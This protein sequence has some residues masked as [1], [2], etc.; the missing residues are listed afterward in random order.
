MTILPPMP[1]ADGLHPILVHFPIALLLTAPVFI[2]LAAAWHARRREML[3]SALVLVALGTLGAVAA[4]WSGE[5]GEHA[6][7]AVASAKP[8]LHDHEELGELARNLFLGMTAILT[9][10]TVFVYK[11][12]ERLSRS[13]G[14]LTCAGLLL[15][16]IAPA[17]VLANAAHQGGRLVHELGVRAWAVET[18]PTGQT[19]PPGRITRGHDD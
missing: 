8:V 19:P 12:G 9:V 16:Y 10:A 11:R 3:L 6:A 17:L 18:A 2:I 7:K 13:A 15:L 5:E 4:A 1:P 14:V